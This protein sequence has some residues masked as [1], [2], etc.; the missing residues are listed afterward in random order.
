[1]LEDTTWI[2]LINGLANATE[3]GVLEWERAAGSSASGLG[4]I[5]QAMVRSL[6]GANVYKATSGSVYYEISSADGFGRAPFQLD[7]REHKGNTLKPFD[8]VK[9]STNVADAGT[10][11]VNMAL[12]RLYTAVA[13]VTESSEQAVDR[14]LRELGQGD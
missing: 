14:F 13:K 5:A 3:Q 8:S 2:K 6:N 1:V 10:Y 4:S 9:S 7:V 12:E 11:K